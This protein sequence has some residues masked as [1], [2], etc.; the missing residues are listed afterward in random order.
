M[1]CAWI[2]ST[3][4]NN[5]NKYHFNGLLRSMRCTYG[6]DVRCTRH[7]VW[8]LETRMRHL[9]T[10]ML[11]IVSN[12]IIF[13]FFSLHRHQLQWCTV[14]SNMFR[15][16]SLTD[17]FITVFASNQSP[18]GDKIVLGIFIQELIGWLESRHW[19]NFDYPNGAE[20]RFDL[21]LTMYKTFQ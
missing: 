8:L 12:A 17:L 19:N 4:S 21:M 18:L 3:G 11:Q 1:E 7:L 10:S 14:R 6:D 9:R 16:F 13:F 20:E 5:A 15:E 2:E